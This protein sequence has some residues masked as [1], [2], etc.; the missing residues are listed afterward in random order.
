[1]KE[2]F[3]KAMVICAAVAIFSVGA[4]TGLSGVSTLL[5][6]KFADFLAKREAT[7]QTTEGA[8]K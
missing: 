5:S 2:T 1:M 3:T 7:F 8:A 4:Y 6:E